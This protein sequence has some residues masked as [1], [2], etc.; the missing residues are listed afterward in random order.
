MALVSDTAPRPLHTV[1]TRGAVFD[2]DEGASSSL[3]VEQIL[4]ILRRYK[5][6]IFGF[7]LIG[8]VAGMLNA[9]SATP[10]YRAETRLL[11]RLGQQGISGAPQFDSAPLHWL[12]F[13]TQTDIIRSRAVAL[14]AVDKLAELAPPSR[15]SAV[16][17]PMPVGK[18][19]QWLNDVRG[20][21]SAFKSDWLPPVTQ[22]W[23]A[24][25]SSAPSG[26]QLSLRERKAAS[27]RGAASVSGGQ[28]S[29]I[30]VINIDS[31]DP[32]YA[33]RVA[34]ALAA[35]YIEFGLGSRIS[36]VQQ[37]TRWLGERIETLRATLLSSEVALREFQAREGMVATQNREQIIASRLSS[38]SVELVR[39]QTRRSEAQVRFKQVQA[40]SDSNVDTELEALSGLVNQDLVMDTYRDR[41]LQQRLVGE[42]SERY[43][44]RHPKMIAVRAKLK[45]TERRLQSELRK[46]IT[47]VRKEYEIATEQERH[48]E[49][50]IDEQQITMRALSGKVFELDKLEK[51]VEANRRI[52]DSFLE[53]FKQ[54]DLA[55]NYD[56]TNV[57]VIDAALVPRT[58]YKPN[59]QRMV[60]MS[61]LVGLLVGLLVATLRSQMDRTFKLKEDVE[62]I[63][64]LPVFGMIPK[65][66]R[67]L[68]KRSQI[69]FI[70]RDE[71]RS[72]FTESISDVR[73][74]LLFSR[75][76]ERLHTVLVTSAVPDEG[77]TTLASNLALSFGHRGRTLLLDGDLRKGRL[78]ELVSDE[79]VRG[80]TD[81]ISGQCTLEEAIVAFPGTE[82]VF[83]LPAGTSAPSPLELLSSQRFVTEFG[84]LKKQFDYI[85]VDGSPLLPVSDSVV[86]ADQCDITVL[87]VQ[88]ER[89]SHALAREAIKRLQAV[90]IR[91]AGVVLQQVDFKRL[92]QYHGDDSGYGRYYV[93]NGYYGKSS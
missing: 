9:I 53:R 74:A 84:R 52:Y 71:P 37:A 50:V 67:T 41:K 23:P 44:E 62:S 64:K 43:G 60:M 5:W 19:A 57:R 45:E 55:E 75:V 92:R 2:L 93:Y 83:V 21:W 66:R 24:M 31:H 22:W 88:S 47:S 26:P 89:T 79:H 76:D 33:A 81:L 16:A 6:S 38:I 54:T 1:A 69:E 25:N 73:T 32:E 72:S 77:K 51:E 30:L 82:Q 10:I 12:Y 3:S 86:L 20:I 40:I 34:N 29:E 35:A 15:P 91:P 65:I 63:L 46:A 27:I 59:K 90:R 18:S 78:N 85:V 70:V 39:A 48:F 49:R 61:T 11:V 68:W 4:R 17:A 36:S 56:G 42:L 13:E 7:V 28:D 14:L 8:C 58:P 87:A 80:L